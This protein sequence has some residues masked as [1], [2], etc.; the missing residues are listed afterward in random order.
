MRVGDEVYITK[1]DDRGNAVASYPGRVIHSDAGLVVAACIWSWEKAVDV[2]P[3][4]LIPGDRL[5]EFYYRG[6]WFNVFKVC[7]ATGRLKGWYCNLTMPAEFDAGQIRWRD[8]KLD[9]VVG[10]NGRAQVADADEFEALEPNPVLRERAEEALATLRAWSRERRGP[11]AGDSA[12][13]KTGA[14]AP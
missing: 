11:F 3:F 14:V 13:A 2:G 5:Y 7:D 9:Y 6:A 1:L 8:L 10:A 4:S 12:C